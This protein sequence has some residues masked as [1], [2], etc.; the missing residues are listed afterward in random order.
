MNEQEILP[1]TITVEQPLVPKEQWGLS[2]FQADGV[3]IKCGCEK[4]HTQ[5]HKGVA[6]YEPCYDHFD[7]HRSRI[8]GD[9]W[10][11]V[12]EFPEHVDRRCT[13]CSYKWVEAVL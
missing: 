8:Q 5:Y 6:T 4:I 3:C 12:S 2:P 9:G 1:L 11:S 13:R 7:A 10:I